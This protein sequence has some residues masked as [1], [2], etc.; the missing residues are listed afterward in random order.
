MPTPSWKIA[1]AIALE[2]LYAVSTRVW[3]KPFL[4]GIALEF[5]ITAV[6]LATAGIY[7]VLFRD[8]ITSRTPQLATARSPLF[9]TAMLTLVLVPLLAGD[10][11]LPDRKTQLVF[12]ATSIAV[13]LR[14]EILYR[15]VLQ[16]LLQRRMHWFAAILTS[17]VLFT[18]YHYGAWPFTLHFVLEFFLVGSAMGFI[19]LATGSLALAVAAHAIYDALWCF[20]PLLDQPL[21][22]PWGSGLEFIAFT[23]LALWTFRSVRNAC[24]SGVN[25]SPDVESTT[26][27]RQSS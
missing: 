25:R 7:W 18:A 6:R 15:G 1:F 3:L 13:A 16:N 8:L 23:L 20:T 27:R 21:A 26:S 10:W 11:G 22:K 17:N 24:G 4:D 19:Y 14:E 5:A 2:I 9:V 12:A